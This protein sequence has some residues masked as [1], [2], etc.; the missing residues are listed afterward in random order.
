[1]KEIIEKEGKKYLTFLELQEKFKNEPLPVF[2]WGIIK[3]YSFGLV[4]GPSK[5]G[6]TIFCELLA[7]AFAVGKKNFFGIPLDGIPRVTLFISLEEYWTERV[8]RNLKQYSSLS[9]SEK[10]LYEKNYRY[11]PTK[12]LG[13]I[14]NKSDWEVLKKLMEESKAE[15]VIIDSITRM[16]HGNIEDSRI[17]QEIMQNLRNLCYELRI[18]LICIHHTPKM[19]GK[20]ITMDSI[21][22]S[23][24]FA[25]ECDF[26][27]GINRTPNKTHYQKN[28][29]ARY[30]PVDDDKGR[31][32]KVDENVCVEFIRTAN[33]AVFFQ[34]NDKRKNEAV[35]NSIVYFFDENS[36]KEFSTKETI[37]ELTKKLNIQERQIKTY[38]SNLVYTK[39]I[40]SPKRGVYKSITCIGKEVSDEE[41]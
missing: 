2:L 18:T 24:V 22:G 11:Q 27:I 32:F 1:M 37:K 9:D 39:R 26:A 29:I 34:Q 6:K 36:C 17:A 28:V 41:K 35:R 33:E 14:K 10:K 3:M 13:N 12:F 30:S 31:E 40:D 15:I 16:N 7:L 8:N 4:F 19:E 25:Q 20:F 23:A 21:K 38:L 5:S